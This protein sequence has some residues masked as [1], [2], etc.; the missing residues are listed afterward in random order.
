MS[1]TTTSIDPDH[2]DLVQQAVDC[3]A[4]AGKLLVDHDGHPDFGSPILTESLAAARGR[5]AEALTGGQLAETDIGDACRVLVD[6]ERVQEQV[7]RT[8]AIRRI[9][10]LGEVHDAAVTLRGLAPQQVIEAA[11]EVVC[12]QLPFARS[13]ISAVSGSLWQPRRLYLQPDL[14]GSPLDFSDYVDAS[15]WSLADAPLETELVRRRVPALVA[16]AAADGRT[17][18]EIISRSRTSSYVAAPVMSAGKV[19]GLLHADRPGSEGGL[20]PDDRDR[21][22]AFTTIL[23]IVYEQA[24]LKHRIQLQRARVEESFDATQTML[25]RISKADAILSHQ[26]AATAD[27]S[28]DDPGESRVLEINSVLTVREREIL[29]HLATGATNN[30]IAQALVISEGTVKS[31]VKTVLKKLH[32]PTRAAATA[33]YSSQTRRA[34]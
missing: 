8:T 26:A 14:D 1:W 23:A 31:H 2:A 34:R 24:V 17:H 6:I 28:T 11:P 30:Q 12:T 9:A 10:E 18:K 5:L 27:S 25:D 20:D 15:V 16:A 19:I 21:L 33:L 7:A 29:S 13:M 22:D 3:I 4:L 32:A